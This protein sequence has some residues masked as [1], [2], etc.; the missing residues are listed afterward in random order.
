MSATVD[1]ITFSVPRAVA[2]D[3]VGLS[4]DLNDRMHQLLERNTDGQLGLGE[5]AELETLVRVA[6]LSQILAMAMQH[7][8]K[9]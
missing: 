8:V 7:Q 6:Q 2:M 4:N 5:K 1:P 3:L 9:P